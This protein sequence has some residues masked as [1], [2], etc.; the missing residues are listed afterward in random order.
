MYIER[1]GSYGSILIYIIVWTIRVSIFPV[2][3]NRVEPYDNTE[4]MLGLGFGSFSLLIFVFYF[5]EFLFVFTY[6]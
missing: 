4:E 2:P 3:R 1:T 6:Y 5:V